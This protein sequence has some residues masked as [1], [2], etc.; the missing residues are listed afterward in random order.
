M[1]KLTRLGRGARQFNLGVAGSVLVLAGALLLSS[2]AN[3]TDVGNNLGSEMPTMVGGLP[4]AA[5]ERPQTP[6]A[7]PAV[8]DMP[9]PRNTKVMTEE[10]KKRAEA[11]LAV[12]REQQTAP[13]PVV[14]RQPELTARRRAK[15][16]YHRV[17][18]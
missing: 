11:E 8:H 3:M 12:M 1:S 9:P 16:V 10:E 13:R 6:P 18:V 17:P 2:C 15:S 14:R 7:F 5:P 4:Q